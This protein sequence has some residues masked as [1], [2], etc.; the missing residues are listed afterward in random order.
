MEQ[1]GGVN[2]RLFF[3]RTQQARLRLFPAEA[4]NAFQFGGSPT[5]KLVRLCL[6]GF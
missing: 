6:E 5:P 3:N 1:A 4:R 2:P